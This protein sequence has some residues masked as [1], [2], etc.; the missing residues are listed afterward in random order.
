MNGETT[1]NHGDNAK[2]ESNSMV[3]IYQSGMK[4]GQQYKNAREKQDGRDR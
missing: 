3:M 2:R 1:V 4:R